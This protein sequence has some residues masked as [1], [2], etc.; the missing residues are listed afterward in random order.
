M[1]G[2]PIG[3]MLLAAALLAAGAAGIAALWAALPR[4][5]STSPLASLF[6]LVWSCTY[7]GAGLLTWRRSR[8]AA[9]AFVAAMGLLLFP[10]SYIFPVDRVVVLPSFA[11]TLLIGF[12]GYRYL[13]RSHEPAS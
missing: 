2:Q 12:L 1:F 3:I 7:I 11:V 8:L 13:R 9:P 10:L 6:A 5:S 4:S